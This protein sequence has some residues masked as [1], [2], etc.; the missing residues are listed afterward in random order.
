MEKLA[1]FHTLVHVFRGFQL[2]YL[3]FTQPGSTAAYRLGFHRNSKLTV[4]VVPVPDPQGIVD[5]GAWERTFNGISALLLKASKAVDHV[6][7][8]RREGLVQALE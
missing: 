6:I 2:A 5:S 3:V 4:S 1:Y 7:L 8:I